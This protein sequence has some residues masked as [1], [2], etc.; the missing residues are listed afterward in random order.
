MKKILILNL[1]I[2]FL[3]SC[4]QQRSINDMD[5]IAEEYV[6]LVLEVG[7][8]D[9]VVIDAYH[10]PEEWKPSELSEEEKLNFPMDK[11]IQASDKLL[12][13]IT[14]FSETGLSES[15][16]MRRLFLE[17]HIIALRAKIQMIGGK[18]FSFEEE[19][20]L[21]YDAEI[22]RY[23][24]QYF[25]DALTSLENLLPGKGNIGERWNEFRSKFVIP[26][27]KLD[28]VFSTAIEEGRKRTLRYI[29]LPDEENFLVEYVKNE[30][31]GA[32]NWYKGNSFS[33]IQVNTDLPVYIDRAVDLASHEGYPG[34]HVFNALL[35][36]NLLVKN[37]WMEF[38]VY[39]LFSPMSLIAEGTANYGIEVAFP[40][41]ERIDYEKNV[42]FPLAGL[43]ASQAEKYYKILDEV[44]KLSFARNEGA[45]RY[46]SGEF[47]REQLIDWLMKY[48]LST[49][50][51]A[52][53]SVDFI[54]KY[55]SYII[56]YNYGLQLCREYIE[57]KCG[58]IEN[59]AKRWELFK[60]LISNPYV[61]S[62]LK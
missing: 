16:R 6:K 53:K 36:Q 1:L 18:K 58:T 43:D 41:K 56:N 40:G 29:K 62:A 14:H 23:D 13:L 55:G 57:R 45:R 3:I 5:S 46:Y 4:Q 20:R 48:R 10:G 21:L 49:R 51:R 12:H 28:T 7:Q 11:L 37:G 54:D 42:L 17:K 44:N 31:W 52:E 8:Y 27:E 24:Q 26:Q 22:L 39:P 2:I 47:D 19:A 61:P 9:P 15:E 34:H 38:S 59:P 33:V 25:I 35:E 50:E 32:Y 60:Q 30:P